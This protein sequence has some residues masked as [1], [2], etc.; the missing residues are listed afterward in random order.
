MTRNADGTCTVAATATGVAGTTYDIA[1]LLNDTSVWTETWAATAGSDSK[2]VSWTTDGSIADGTYRAAVTIVSQ[3]SGSSAR[4]TAADVFLVGDVAAAKGADA[5]EQGLVPGSFVL[6]RSGAAALPLTV[7]YSVAS[8]TA[9]AGVSYQAV[10]G[11]AT[12]AAGESTVSVAIVPRNDPALKSDATLTLTVLAGSGLYGGAGTTADITLFDFPVPEGYNAWIAEADGNA[13]D[14]ANWSLGRA[15]VEG[16]NILLGAWSLRNITWDAAATHAVASWTQT[17]DYDAQV[18]FPI[19]YEGA[20]V[21]AGFNLFTVAGDVSILAGAWVHPV[22]GES[23][24]SGDEPA[25]R[26]RIA[27]QAGGGFTVGTGVNISALGRGR[28]F[29][30]DSQRHTFGIHGGYGITRTNDMYAAVSDPWFTPCGSILEPTETGRGS[31]TGTDSPATSGHGGGAIHIVAGGAFVNNGRIVADGQAPTGNSGGSGGS[32]YVRAASISGTG[33]FEADATVATGSGQRSASSGGRVALVATGANSA[34]AANA[35]AN[36]ARSPDWWQINNQPYWEA[37]AGTVWLQSGE[38]RELLVRNIV[39]GGL[40]PY[41]RAY[42]PIPCGD[43]ASA[44]KAAFA[45]ATLKASD[46]ARVRIVGNLSFDALE[47]QTSAGSLA[48]VDLFG[49]KLK[50]SRIIDANG[51]V[52]ASSGSYTLEQA[53]ANGW[54]WFEDSSA[55]LNAEGTAIETAGTGTLVVG[56][57]G[58]SIIVR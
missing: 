15:P 42:T 55:T 22:Q 11:T 1:V 27:V 58:F 20:D 52:L 41:V 19:T 18:V 53:L 28:G 14:G 34:S 48:H 7:A 35:S 32:V 37:A 5:Y 49:N 17:A 29:W 6:S 45:G 9:T 57:S 40:G 23:S 47:V 50:V 24:K 51:T 46:N 3:T 21:D 31:S 10:S 4:R 26:Y 33:T 16:D 44:A 38:S 2:V 25:Q 56:A 39:E 13:S 36:G 8:A 12:F 43:D 30:T 54:T